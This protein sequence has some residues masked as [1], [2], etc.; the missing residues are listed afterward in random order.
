MYEI[1]KRVDIP[2]IITY[3]YKKRWIDYNRPNNVPY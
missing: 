3:I 1:K 2:T